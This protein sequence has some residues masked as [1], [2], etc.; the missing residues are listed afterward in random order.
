MLNRRPVP[1][2][3]LLR[4][5]LPALAAVVCAH[6]LTAC[7]CSPRSSAAG[8]PEHELDRFRSD[9]SRAVTGLIA[10]E[11]GGL[12][13]AIRVEPDTL[14]TVDHAL[15]AGA[16]PEAVMLVHTGGR[17]PESA[18]EGRQIRVRA[19]AGARF[20]TSNLLHLHT[21]R[22]SPAAQ[23]AHW[24]ARWAN[25][26]DRASAVHL[27][28]AHMA[29]FGDTTSLPAPRIARKSPPSPGETV[30]LRG[31]IADPLACGVE[32]ITL[33]GVVEPAPPP[34]TND[35]MFLV[36]IG[37]SAPDAWTFQHFP[38]AGVVR[39]SDSGEE[40]VVGMATMRMASDSGAAS[41]RFY[42]IPIP[43]TNESNAGS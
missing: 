29:V 18:G 21:V 28:Y 12:A 36:R 7:A 13:N 5:L 17:A 8:F 30:E 4:R 37:G 35:E 38:G 22:G 20:T 34:Y 24:P 2:T 19:V 25:P 15:P 6:A 9:P 16:S 43:A 42:A 39:V 31:W 26:A 14:L 32:H 27:D 33:P 40:T 1:F 3:A 10:L 41:M 11:R 23:A